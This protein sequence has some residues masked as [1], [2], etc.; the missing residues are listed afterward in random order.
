M[1]P[2]DFRVFSYSEAERERIRRT[3]MYAGAS[4]LDL[5][6]LLY[7]AERLKL[8]LLQRP[9]ELRARKVTLGSEN[10]E[11]SRL[12]LA[13]PIESFRRIA[14]RTGK[15]ERTSSPEFIHG[16]YGE[17]AGCRITVYRSDWSHNRSTFVNLRDYDDALRHGGDLKKR[18]L[19]DLAEANA[20]K[21]AFPSELSAIYYDATD[22]IVDEAAS[23]ALY[24]HEL[25]C[26]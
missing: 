3:C 16:E 11:K 2:P 14:Q 15:L 20:L 19:A 5:W 12:I 13:A 22:A 9:A 8:D 24:R 21:Q 10:E 6:F 1:D 26:S 23:E 17:L 7:H 18:F 4:D 25:D